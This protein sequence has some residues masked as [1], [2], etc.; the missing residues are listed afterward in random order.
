L[1]NHEA[2]RPVKAL[3]GYTFSMGTQ[4]TLRRVRYLANMLD[5]RFRV[6]FTRFTFGWDAIL[7]LLPVAGDTIA[8]FIGAGIIV[9]AWRAGVT[10][11]T[12]LHMVWNLF[13]DWLVGLVPVLDLI[14]DVAFKANLRNARLLESALAARALVPDE[15]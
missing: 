2:D 4:D 5:S 14:F 9:I 12:L 10:W 6:P 7:G 1:A 8:M 3:A 13:V 11:R 15:G